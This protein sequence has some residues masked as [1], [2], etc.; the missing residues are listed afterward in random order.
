MSNL[1]STTHASDARQRLARHIAAREDAAASLGAA[2]AALER[3]RRAKALP[4][5]IEEELG[6]L[7]AA[8]TAVMDA[9]SRSGSDEPPPIAD[10]AKRQALLK[11]LDDARA[12]AG[13]AERA[14]ASQSAEY[15]AA[16]HRLPPIAAQIDVAL[17]AVLVE[18]AEPLFV[19]IEAETRALATKISRA[20]LLVDIVRES[21]QR[22]ADR[23]AAGAIFPIVGELADRKRDAT[24][25][26]M[27]DL[28]AAGS[29]R[30]EWL[31]LVDRLRDDAEA[32]LAVE[33]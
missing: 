19:E 11:R 24:S 18:E 20:S 4:A 14:E 6:Q 31:A 8:E 10:A 27:L 2:G 9:W 33:A 7:D 12:A 22:Q 25:Q 28:A 3:L 21:A 30:A 5:P 16:A 23:E 32:T 15:V 26:P 17:A 29:Q 13:A 1:K